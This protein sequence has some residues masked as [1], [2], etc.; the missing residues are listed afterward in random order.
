MDDREA[1]ARRVDSRI[2]FNQLP[3]ER[4][5][6]AVLGLGFRRLADFRKQLAEVVVEERQAMQDSGGVGVILGQLLLDRQR[7]AELDLRG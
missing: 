5:S 4:E 6:L 2:A 7:R 1:A 3:L